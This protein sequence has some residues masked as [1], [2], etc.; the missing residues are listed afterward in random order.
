LQTISRPFILRR[1]FNCA[2]ITNFTPAEQTLYKK[3]SMDYWMRRAIEKEK[4][5][6]ASDEGTSKGL[7][8]GRVEGREKGANDKAKD[9]AKGMLADGMPVVSVAKYTQISEEVVNALKGE[10]QKS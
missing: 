5:L 6:K 2:E 10:L 7:E 1:L 8:R 3:E 9:I 4:F